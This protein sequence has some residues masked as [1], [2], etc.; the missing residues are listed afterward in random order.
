M[1]TNVIRSTS[2]ILHPM[3]CKEFEEIRM[4][5][6]RN[7]N[8]NLSSSWVRTGKKGFFWLLIIEDLSCDSGDFDGRVPTTGTREW[9]NQLG[10]TIKKPWYPW[11]HTG[12]RES[13][14]GGGQV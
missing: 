10:L 12:S 2:C 6:C 4:L 7:A 8:D 9:I 1:N 14:T 11:V 13:K 5:W 3:C